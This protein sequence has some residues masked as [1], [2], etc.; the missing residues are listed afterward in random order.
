[1]RTLGVSGTLSRDAEFGITLSKTRMHIR[2]VKPV[3]A[4]V[5]D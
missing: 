3:F 1:M 2:P 5:K 4:G